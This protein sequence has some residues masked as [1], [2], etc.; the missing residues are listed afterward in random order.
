VSRLEGKVAIITGSGSGIGRA[1]AI[2]FAEEGARVI[3]VDIDAK[4]G[5]ETVSQ[6]EEKNGEAEFIKTNITKTDEVKALVQKVISDYGRI[7]VI[8]NNA[9]G[10][11]KGFSDTVIDTEES[12]WNRLMDLNLKSLYLT[13]KEVVPHMIKARGGSIINTIT[14]NASVVTPGTQAYSAAKAGALNLTKSL[15]IE[16]GKYGIRANG[17]SPGEVLTPQ[18]IA[19]IKTA[20]DP[21]RAKQSMI[22]KIPL[23]RLAEPED[24]AKVALWLASDDSKYISGVIIPV[25]GG[26]TAGYTPY[27]E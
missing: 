2:L 3:V 17:I 21:E 15:C 10:W 24:V 1:T 12:E 6:I 27:A 20:P 7:D 14:M 18:W 4:G 25:D 11:S 19:T 5:E 9:G 8:Y 23:G 16:F 26:L 22:K 13:S